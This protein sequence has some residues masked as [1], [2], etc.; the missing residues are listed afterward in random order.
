MAVCVLIERPTL[1]AALRA[2]GLT[3]VAPPAATVAIVAARALADA[4]ACPAARILAVATNESDE[5]AALLAGADDASSGSDT[6]IALRARRL[7]APAAAITIGSLHIDRITRTARRNGCPL[8][9]LPR[10][11]ALL[12]LLARHCNQTVTRAQLHQALFGLRFDP[13]TNVLAVHVSRLRAA[14]ER[15]GGAPMLLTDRGRGYRLIPDHPP[16][17]PR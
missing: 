14:L 17:V 16:P 6:T 1:P 7:L 8:S 10:E 9:L 12:D 2:V 5:R 13:G 15:E 4:R 3:L 11:Y